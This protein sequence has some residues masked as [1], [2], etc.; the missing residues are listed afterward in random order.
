M[1]LSNFHAADGVDAF[2]F[3]CFAFAL[4]KASGT[5]VLYHQDGPVMTV[6][7]VAPELLSSS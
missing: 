6:L 5:V 4:K 7:G 1:L 3:F 2:A